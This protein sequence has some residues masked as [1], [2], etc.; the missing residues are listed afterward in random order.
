MEELKIKTEKSSSANGTYIALLI[1]LII[2]IGAAIYL[3]GLQF[4]LLDFSSFE[5]FL[6]TF[7]SPYL[8]I[9]LA[10]LGIDIFLIGYI[11]KEHFHPKKYIA[12]L[13]SIDLYDSEE[14][15]YKVNFKLICEGNKE[16]CYFNPDKVF[17]LVKDISLLKTDLKYLISFRFATDSSGEV[18]KHI[19]KYDE[20]YS[21]IEKKYPKASLKPVFIMFILIFGGMGIHYLLVLLFKLI[22][23][24]S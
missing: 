16:E 1:F 6:L 21:F 12:Q 15:L 17:C 5:T 19:Y 3:V 13:T 22:N 14:N 2:W 9:V 20:T 24:F 11:I 10:I 23:L 8:G 7:F 18:I 4:Y